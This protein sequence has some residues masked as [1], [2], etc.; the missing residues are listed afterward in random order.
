MKTELESVE[1]QFLELLHQLGPASIQEMGKRLGV[2]ATAVRQRLNRLRGLGLIERDLERVGRG[3][4]LHRYRVTEKALRML[5]D[6]YSDL[7]LILWK[8]FKN[9]DNP[10]IRNELR[11]KVRDALAARFGSVQKGETILERLQLLQSEMRE[12]GYD[13]A[14]EERDGLPI[15]KENNC[16][17]HE[18]AEVDREICELEQDVFTRLLGVPIRLTSCCQDD[19]RCCEFEMASQEAPGAN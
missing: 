1:R 12:R 10:Q 8:E 14:V 17:Y 9:I 3:R 7:A 4:P 2:T 5:G 18:L 19:H 16:P 13:L 11:N 6:N 15:L